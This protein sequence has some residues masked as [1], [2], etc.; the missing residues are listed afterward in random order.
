[1]EHTDRGPRKQISSLLV[2]FDT[3]GVERAPGY[4]CVSNRGYHNFILNFDDVRVPAS[5]LL[6]DEHRGF[7]VANEWLGSTRLQVA[8]VCPGT[9]RPGPGRGPSTGP[10]PASSSGSR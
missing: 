8:A 1:M 3:P 7:D 9:G 2:D 6:G 10:R 4:N 5:K